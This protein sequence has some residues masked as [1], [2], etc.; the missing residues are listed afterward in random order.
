MLINPQ[1][2]VEV[3]SNST[4]ASDRGDKFSYYKSIRSFSDYLLI[5]QHCPHVSQFAK[6]GDGFWA[7]FEF[8]DLSESIELRSVGYSIPISLIYRGATFPPAN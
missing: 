5:A 3:V 2:I 7:N 6:H 1:L 8:N 4:E